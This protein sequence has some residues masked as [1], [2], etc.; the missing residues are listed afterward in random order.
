MRH[1]IV[2]K[3]EYKGFYKKKLRYPVNAE[4]AAYMRKNQEKCKAISL[5]NPNENWF[6][7]KLKGAKLGVKFN[8]QTLWGYRIYDFWCHS[9]GCAVEIDGPDH[10]ENYDHYRDVYNYLRSGIVVIRVRNMNEVDALEAMEFIKSLES[11]DVRRIKLNINPIRKSSKINIIREN[12]DY[13]A[14]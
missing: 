8:R 13:W 5:Q 7:D 2:D 14:K 11:W 3:E 1:N 10:D 12:S 9:I 4:M 6:A